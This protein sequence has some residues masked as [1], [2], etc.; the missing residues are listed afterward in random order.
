MF[1]AGIPGAMKYDMLNGF[2]R[3]AVLAVVLGWFRLE[4]TRSGQYSAIGRHWSAW[5]GVGLLL[6]LHSVS[7]PRYYSI[8]PHDNVP[9]SCLRACLTEV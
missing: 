5:S 7:S 8:R 9:R 1:D 2:F 3:V 6:L 4:M